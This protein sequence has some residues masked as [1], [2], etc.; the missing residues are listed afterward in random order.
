[1]V[2]GRRPTGVRWIAWRPG[3]GFGNAAQAYI[4]GLDRLGIPITWTP[5]EWVSGERK[6]RVALDYHGPLEH[7]GLLV[8]LQE[9][10]RGPDQVPV[11]AVG[12]PLV[13]EQ[14]PLWCEHAPEGLDRQIVDQM[15]GFR[16]RSKPEHEVSDTR[17]DALWSRARGL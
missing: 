5:I 8:D 12:K 13:V 2:T 15:E 3:D 7:L 11:H 1:M 9:G 17:N 14:D 16:L 4:A 10:Q 6:A